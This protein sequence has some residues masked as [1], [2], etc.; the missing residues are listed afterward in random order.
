LLSGAPLVEELKRSRLQG[1]YWSNTQENAYALMALA[2]L[3]KQSGEGKASVRVLRGEQLL[4][5]LSV[6]GSEAESLSRTLSELGDGELTLEPSGP[7]YFALRQR[8]VREVSDNAAV[9]HGFAV[10]RRYEDLATGRLVDSVKLGQLVKVKLTVK[11]DQSARWVAL[12][13]PLPAGFEPVNSKLK[14]EEGVLRGADAQEWSW[15][16]SFTA[17]HDDRAL[18]F[19]DAMEAGSHVHEHVLRATSTGTFTA[20]PAHIEAMYEPARMAST[21]SAILVVTP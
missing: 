20:P 2:Q 13:D 6:R 10:E 19:S 1:G 4:A 21:A 14:T 8:R 12:V 5:T 16:W 11:A 17:Q 3:A 18:A 15:V 9:E 7:V